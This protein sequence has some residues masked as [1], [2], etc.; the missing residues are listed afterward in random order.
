DHGLIG[1]DCPLRTGREVPL[2]TDLGAAGGFRAQRWVTEER[3]IQI[4]EGGGLEGGAPGGGEP[5][6]IREAPRRG[7]GARGVI[8]ELLIMIVTRR[9]IEVQAPRSE[10]VGAEGA[11]VLARPRRVAGI[12]ADRVALLIDTEQQILGGGQAQVV[13]PGERLAARVEET[14][15]RV[16]EELCGFVETLA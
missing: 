4:V 16:V 7:R 12:A 10:A 15:R 11:G 2:D 1:I 3:E 9:D 8:A 13:E 5:H 14:V 6:A